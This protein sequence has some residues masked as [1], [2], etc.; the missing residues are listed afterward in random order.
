MVA[1]VVELREVSC[2]VSGCTTCILKVTPA[3][4]L[5]RLILV[6]SLLQVGGWL[7]VYP[8]KPTGC[9]VQTA[10]PFHVNYLNFWFT[11]VHSI[12]L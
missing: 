2:H 10:E 6:P 5:G 4:R 11:V 9:W 7:L 1:E 8:D 12:P 3:S